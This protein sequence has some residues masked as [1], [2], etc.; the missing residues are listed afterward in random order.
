MAKQP[1]SAQLV[2]TYMHICI[3]LLDRKNNNYKGEI[4]IKYI[5]V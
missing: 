3:V 4:I 1:L 2:H 5:N